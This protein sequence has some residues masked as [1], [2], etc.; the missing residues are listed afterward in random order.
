MSLFRWKCFTGMWQKEEENMKERR[1]SREVKCRVRVQQRR[2]K[3][4]SFWHSQFSVIYNPLLLTC[5][6]YLQPPKCRSFQLLIGHW[7]HQSKLWENIEIEMLKIKWD[8]PRGNQSDSTTHH[9]AFLIC[10]PADRATSSQS[11]D[12][13]SGKWI[14]SGNYKVSINLPEEIG[15]V[16]WWQL[17]Q[18]PTLVPKDS[19]LSVFEWDM[20]VCVTNGRKDYSQS[21]WAALQQRDRLL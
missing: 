13:H 4:Q 11:H 2:G 10:L 16:W 6:E 8:I 15:A 7:A 19:K 1:E 18:Q 14:L 21:H 12:I 3:S 9:L 20:C 17:H 5:S